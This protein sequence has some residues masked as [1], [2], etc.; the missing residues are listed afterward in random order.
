[1]TS[2]WLQLADLTVTSS[3]ASAYIQLWKATIQLL[4]GFI[5]CL[6]L[7]A[8]VLSLVLNK[9]LKPLKQIQKSA[10]EMAAT[11]SPLHYQHLILV[12]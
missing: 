6:L 12:N 8:I 9:V 7:G 2:G 11:I 10:Q 5:T 1:M 3:P 4:F